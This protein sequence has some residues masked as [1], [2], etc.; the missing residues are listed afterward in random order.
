MKTSLV[1]MRILAGDPE[2]N[3][4]RA[5]PLVLEAKR[6]GSELVLLPELWLPGYALEA[7]H[8]L[9]SPLGRGFFERIARLARETGLYI[10][11]SILEEENGRF[12]NTATV[13]DPRG[14]V[15]L[16]YRKI[17]LFA[18]IGERQHLSPGSD[19]PLWDSPWGKVAFALCYDL[20]FPELF[21]SYALRGAVVVLVPAQWPLERVEHWR[22]LL[23]ARA[24]ENLSFVAGC[25]GTGESA[26]VILG[27]HSA[28]YSP[29]GELL[30]EAGTQEAILTVE[31]N[32][33]EATRLRKDFPVLED[34]RR[35]EYLT[36]DDGDRA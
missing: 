2:A 13:I 33:E 16:A 1:Q 3:W 22:L 28:V 29:W 8:R 20:R 5:V 31:L 7:A 23:R 19:A 30:I 17:H 14:D 32:P 9:A 12:F 34:A 36:G 6:R 15:A 18:P 25:N 4:A 11:G 24:V 21:R 10:A 26:G 35:A 27:G